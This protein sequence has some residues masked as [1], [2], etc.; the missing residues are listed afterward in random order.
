MRA[1]LRAV[2]TVGA[3]VVAALNFGKLPPALTELREEFGLSLVAVGW[4]TSLLNLSAALLGIAGGSIADRFG[5]RRV[6]VSGLL[7]IGVAGLLGALASS[8]LMIFSARLLESLG[9]ML[10]VLP[11]PALLQRCVPPDRLRGWLGGWGAYMPLGMS[12]MLFAGPWFMSLMGWRGSW[13]AG[14]LISF[15]WAW[16]I[17]RA[18]PASMPDQGRTG[19]G[20]SLLELAGITVSAPGPWLL[21]T[22]FMFYAAQFLGIFSFL[23]TIYRDAGIDLR[24][25]GALTAI[26]VLGNALGNLASGHFL[27][28]GARR[29]TLILVAATVMGTSSWVLFGSGA[30]FIVQY[31][32][33]LVFSITAGLTP[34]VLFASV[35]AYAPDSRAVSTTVGLMQ[36]GSGIGQALSPPLVAWLVQ[37][38][39]DWSVTWIATSACALGAALVA[40]G[41]RRLDARR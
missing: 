31:S 38:N 33:A 12:L 23:P 24:L 2:I 7:I 15:L 22:G 30:P 37:A 32:A 6:M 29:S 25:G 34:G 11:G 18:H 5:Y 28:A 13:T 1:E 21:A 16:L 27:Q 17:L 40:L 20:P 36:Q 35:P 9:M 10:T 41:M 14:A 26:A 39:G 19:A 4:L 8:P 3:G